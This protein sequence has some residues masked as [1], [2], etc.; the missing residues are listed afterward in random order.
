MLHSIVHTIGPTALLQFSPALP[1]KIFKLFLICEVKIDNCNL[2]GRVV[3]IL[4]ACGKYRYL[5]MTLTAVA[6]VRVLKRTEQILT[7]C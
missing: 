1:F 7:F 5:H 3:M 4:I 2:K 6:A